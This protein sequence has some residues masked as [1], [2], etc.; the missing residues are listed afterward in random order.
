MASI[1]FLRPRSCVPW[2]CN[3]ADQGRWDAEAWRSLLWAATE[4]GDADFQIAVADQLLRIPSNDLNE[5]LPTA[6]SWFRTR[7]D[8]LS[9]SDRPDG[10]RFLSLWDRLADLTFV[11][12]DEKPTVLPDDDLVTEAL[13][14]PGG[15]LAWA[16]VGALSAL[17]LNA[18][19]GLPAELKPRFNKA[20]EGGGR[21]GL[22][23]RVYFAPTLAYLDAID[24]DWTSEALTSRLSWDQPEALPLWRAYAHGNM[25][26]ARLFNAV[27]PAMLEAFDRQHLSD[28]EFESIVSRLLSVCVC[29]R[30]GQALDCDLKPS[31]VKRALSIGPPAA[32]RNVAWNL[33][34][35]MGGSD[36]E[37][38]D[39]AAR[40][41]EIVGPVFRDIWPL[42][43][44]LRSQDSTRNLVQMALEC[45]FAFPEA[46]A[47]IVDFLVPYELFQ[48]SHSLRLEQAHGE[49]D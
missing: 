22:L 48:I 37:P 24:P 21:P 5:I 42:D 47:E 30:R 23:A 12:A 29:H 34:R 18:G 8:L 28:F 36:F 17:K 19:R 40:W 46:V 11:T 13:N 45:D 2:T 10:S 15:M 1:L 26:S 35:I 14:A 20:A 43:A 6:A 41:R 33:W 49:L 9:T 4:K 38:A 7:R 25:G 3:E 16:L 44:K 31:E 39:K 32:R 27:K